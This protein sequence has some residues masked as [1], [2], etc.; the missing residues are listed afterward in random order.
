MRFPWSSAEHRA[1]WPAP[2][3]SLGSAATKRRSEV[4]PPGSIRAP[5]AAPGSGARK[6]ARRSPADCER[7]DAG[8]SPRD[9]CQPGSN[10]QYRTSVFSSVGRANS[11]SSCAVVSARRLGISGLSQIM[12]KKHSLRAMRRATSASGANQ[13]RWPNRIVSPPKS[14]RSAPRATLSPDRPRIG[15]EHGRQNPRTV[16]G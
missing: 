13:D 7:A 4:L 6:A 2:G 9:R 15:A 12:M 14:S 3:A 1:P 5:E 11:S 8:E 10:A 16:M